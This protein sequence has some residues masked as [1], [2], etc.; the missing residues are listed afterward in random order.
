MQLTTLLQG[1]RTRGKR[2]EPTRPSISERV[3]NV[4]SSQWTATSAPTQTEQDAYRYAGTEF[5]EVLAEFR[6][7]MSDLVA[8]ET[9]NRSGRSALDAGPDSDVGAGKVTDSSAARPADVGSF[10]HDETVGAWPPGG[11]GQRTPQA[12]W[13]RASTS[14]AL[15]RARWAPSRKTSWT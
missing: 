4:V 15:V 9:K 11:G 12:R 7:L 5:A 10:N 13:A 6:D 8:L 3:Q 1:D 14:A 2:N